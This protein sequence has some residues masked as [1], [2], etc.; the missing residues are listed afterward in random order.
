MEN[1]YNYKTLYTGTPKKLE[2]CPI[3]YFY[4]K[5]SLGFDLSLKTLDKL[6]NRLSKEKTLLYCLRGNDNFFTKSLEGIEKFSF[7]LIIYCSSSLDFDD[8]KNNSIIGYTVFSEPQRVYTISGRS[9]GKLIIS[10][11]FRRNESDNSN[12]I[13]NILNTFRITQMEQDFT[14][15][16]GYNFPL[17]DKFQE[18]E[19][20][21]IRYTNKIS[22]LKHDSTLI[23]L[24]DNGVAYKNGDNYSG[25]FIQQGIAIEQELYTNFYLGTYKNDIVLCEFNIKNGNFCIISLTRTNKFKNPYTYISGNLDTEVISG[26]EVLYYAYSYLVFWDDYNNNYIVYFLEDENYTICPKN[27]NDTGG[28]KY[29]VIDSRD[30]YGKYKY[31]SDS[32]LI[33][34]IEKTCITPIKIDSSGN[35]MVDLDRKNYI[36]QQKIGSWWELLRTNNIY[37]YLSPFG[38]VSSTVKLNIINDRLFRTQDDIFFPIEFGHTYK[39]PVHKYPRDLTTLKKVGIKITPTDLW[40]N[41]TRSQECL[42]DGIRRKPVRSRR[43]FP[44]NSQIIGSLYGIT[45]YIENEHLYCY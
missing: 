19:T 39:Y 28:N 31:M 44:E 7:D 35:Y 12:V 34:E 9:F 13:V 11:T 18:P 24:T 32:N 8:T 41:L 29:I 20:S 43:C 1:S 26:C 27:D 37:Y 38:C 17:S 33:E 22:D 23:S 15:N 30:P 40:E 4:S 21:Y 16:N 42:L 3:I 10:L 5:S 6:K 2:E 36:Y 45:F 25:L 14:G